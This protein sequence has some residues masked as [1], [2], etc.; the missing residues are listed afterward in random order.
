ML[1]MWEGQ[2]TGECVWSRVGRDE[3]RKEKAARSV[4]LSLSGEPTAFY[5]NVVFSL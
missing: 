3:A 1:G 2:D 5:L 4:V